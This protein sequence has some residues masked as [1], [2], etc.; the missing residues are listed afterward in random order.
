MIANLGE[1]HDLL[2]RNV[3]Q[4]ASL[5]D[6]FVAPENASISTTLPDRKVVLMREHGFTTWGTTIE[7]AVFRAVFTTVN[8]QVQTNSMSL[9]SAFSN[10]ANQGVD[11]AAWGVDKNQIFRN[12][13]VPLT[14]QQA[15]DTDTSIG[16][17]SARPWG[18]W[19]A[20][21]EASPL[22]TNNGPQGG[23]PS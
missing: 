4:G 14:E 2:V 15:R 9:R 20:E 8:A 5:A 11:L 21:V 7:E 19:V 16:A 22:Y 1:V 13:F 10:M 23:Q 18:L 12:D 17:T 6:A 3:G